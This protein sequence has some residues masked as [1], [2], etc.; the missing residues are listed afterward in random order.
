MLGLVRS[1]NERPNRST[2]THPEMK[3]LGLLFSKQNNQILIKVPEEKLDYSMT[4]SKDIISKLTRKY[5]NE[6]VKK[7][8]SYL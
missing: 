5:Q 7:K 6:K 3:I 2:L 1:L 8:P 4:V